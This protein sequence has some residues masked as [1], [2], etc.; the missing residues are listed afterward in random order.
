M[1]YFKIS[2]TSRFQ[3]LI[4][5]YFRELQYKNSVSFCYLCFLIKPEDFNA[6]LNLGIICS[7]TEISK[8]YSIYVARYGR[9]K[10]VYFKI[11][12]A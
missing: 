1:S 9:L 4:E 6:L 8:I 7:N 5:R 11:P 3:A 10:M 2:L 12:Y